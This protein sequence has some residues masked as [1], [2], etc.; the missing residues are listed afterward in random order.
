MD[1]SKK[2]ELDLEDDEKT[3]Y[4]NKVYRMCCAS[5]EVC[6]N[7]LGMKIDKYSKPSYIQHCDEMIEHWKIKKDTSERTLK[8]LIEQVC[9]II[10]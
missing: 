10:I 1:N 5:D 7:I 3:E 6:Q 4:I 9:P 8:D 2:T